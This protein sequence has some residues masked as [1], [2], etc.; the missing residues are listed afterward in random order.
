[1]GK[2][3]FSDEIGVS[4]VGIGVLGERGASVWKRRSPPGA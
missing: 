1:V 4:G 3:R 2:L